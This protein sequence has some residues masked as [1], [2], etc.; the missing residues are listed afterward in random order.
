MTS[1]LQKIDTPTRLRSLPEADL[2]LLASEV[3]EFTIDTVA[4]TG[5]HLG[6]S[7]GVVELTI[8][9]HYVFNTPED[10][11]IWDV[12]H[13]SYPHKILTGRRERMHTLRQKQGLSGFTKRSESIYDPFGA[14]HSSTSISAAMGMAIA[15]RQKGEKRKCIAVIGDGAMTAGMSFEALNDAGQHRGLGLVVVLN[16]NEMSIS[17]NVGAMS[18]YLSRI[19]SGRVYTTIKDGTGRVLKK[20]SEP[21]LGAA[22]R[23]E[24]H[25]KGMITPGTLFEE[26]GFTYFG[27]IDGHDFSQL[28]PTLR[29]IQRLSGPILLHV[30]TRKGKGFPPAEA[31]PCTYH[32]VQP[33]DRTTGRLQGNGVIPSFTQVFGETLVNLAANDPRIVAVTAAMPEGTGLNLFQERFPER[34]FDVGIAEQHAVTFAAGLACEGFLP[35]VAIYSTFLQRAYDQVVHDVALQGLP[36]VLAVDRGGIVGED[37]ATHAGAFDLSYLRAIPNLVL[38]APADENE[39][40]H[41]LAT[42]LSL[43]RPVALRYPRGA[44]MGLDPVVPI[45]L[46]P[47][48]GR[49]LRDGKGIALVAVGSMVHA[50][51]GATDILKRDGIQPAVYDARFIKP[52]D[53]ALLREAASH[54][55]LVVLEENSV[56]GGFGAAVLEFL[57]QEGLFDAGLRVRTWGM[58]D[59]FVAQ[60]SRKEMRAELSLDAEGVARRVRELMQ[61][62][63]TPPRP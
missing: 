33:F 7:L 10:R 42:A 19:L 3:R 20:I 31:S 35:V 24:E 52:L 12:G 55:T 61:A 46:P 45:S 54:G 2:P 25:M 26:L 27:P 21:L 15:A 8:A 49:R 51:L 58:P 14:G 4:R 40:R 9:L 57:A 34:F 30:V 1:L 23:A 5:G 62:H 38:M 37:G 39:L 47:G 36:M 63:A 17:P 59:A 53:T 60:G 50:A 11:L 44:A 56:C 41:M 16:D 29:N 18:A 28:L 6:A 43:K 13:Q 48:I 22:R 32:G